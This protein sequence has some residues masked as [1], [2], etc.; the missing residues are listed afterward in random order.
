MSERSISPERLSPEF[1]GMR[2][3]TRISYRLVKGKGDRRCVLVHSLAMDKTF[4]NPTVEALAAGADVLIYDCRGHGASDKPEGPYSV[5]QFAGDVADL[6]DHVGWKSATVAGASM[7][8]CVALAFAAGFPERVEALGLFDTTAWYGENAPQAWAERAEKAI[9]GGMAALVAFQKTRWFSDAFREADPAI[10][11]AAI[12]VF[13]ANDLKAYAATCLM[14][15]QADI[16][17]ALPTF[18]FPCRVVVG[19]EDYATPPD[20]ARAMA[21]A[22]PGATLDILQGARHFTPLE[23]P[24]IIA[25][26]LDLLLDASSERRH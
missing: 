20:M 16:R 13:L 19:S 26:H 8:G 2:D 3:G 14:L 22:I 23:V 11:E 7:G 15:G 1:A 10:V 25:S 24:A 4:W 9:E 17:S 12:A 6:M 21:G 18:N 5:E